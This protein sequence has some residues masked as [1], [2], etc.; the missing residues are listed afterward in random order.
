M[1]ETQLATYH[2]AW[3]LLPLQSL[4]I[5]HI[6]NRAHR[7][8]CSLTR[9]WWCCPQV[10]P[11]FCSSP[12]ERYVY[13]AGQKPAKPAPVGSSGVEPCGCGERSLTR[14]GQRCK[15]WTWR[16]VTF[17]SLI[18]VSTSISSRSHW[19]HMDRQVGS[20]NSSLELTLSFAVSTVHSLS[21]FSALSRL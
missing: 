12:S 1:V 18:S 17:Q 20:G 14:I 15:R 6:A 11:S 10:L 16:S 7:H 8:E 9:S 19:L 3:V 5:N 21:N 4:L 2:K 13:T